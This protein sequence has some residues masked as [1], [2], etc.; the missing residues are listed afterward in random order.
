MDHKMVFKIFL[1]L[2][3]ALIT[4]DSSWSGQKIKI[5]HALAMAG[6][7]KYAEDFKH[8]DYANPNAPKGGNIK[9]GA[10]GT[11]DSLNPFII[12]GVPATGIGLI[13]DTLTVQ[14]LDEPF[15]QYGLIAAKI[16]LP[17][18]RSWVIYHINSKAIF[19]DG[20][21]ITAA[22]VVFS[23]NLLMEKGDP[24]YS[25]YWADVKKVEALDDLRVKFYLGDKTNPE[26]A[27]IIGQIQVMPKHYWE[28]RDFTQP[29]LEV[30]IASGPYKVLEFKPGR[31]ITY[32]R[33][34]DYWAKD[35][36]V[37]KG[38][39]NFDT[40]TYDYYR[41]PT[42]SLHAFKAGEYDFRQENSSRA[43]ATA[44]TGPPF[45]AGFIIKEEI[46]N[47]VNQ[48][49]QGFVFNTRRDLF[50]DRKVREAL[51]YAFDFEWTNK[52]LFFGQY[53]RSKSYFS[54]SELAA[55]GLPGPGELKILESYRDQLPG[56]VFDKAYQP[57][58]TDGSGNIRSNIRKALR[59]LKQAGWKI[60][61]KKLVNKK[62]GDPFI[63]ELLL[64]DPAFERVALPFKKNLSRLG[65]EMNIRVVDTAQFINRRRDFD[66]DMIVARIPQSESPG[67]EQREYWGSSAADITGTSNY[68]GI[69]NPVIDDI[70]EQVTSAPGRDELVYTTRALDRVLLWG[71]YVI[72]QW[73]IAKYRVAYWNKFSRPKITARYSLGFDTWWIDAG[74][75][76][77]LLDFKGNLKN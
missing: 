40:M 73:H 61:G 14:S 19:H 36:P 62:S 18:D 27:L 15:T 51:T 32:Q 39:Y 1:V 46:D 34:D 48:G 17:Q 2:M 56:E 26:L 60:Q 10:V 44:Y 47:D 41:D 55:S 8:F 4:A 72:P 76:A 24:M 53:T 45:D 16:E 67:N 77:K 37:N 3:L 11:F 68:A 74:K 54:N 57:P 12:R 59:L 63:L 31:S 52:T 49:M 35:H 38:R 9:L 64:I 43:W 33:H 29:G 5:T 71:Y 70:I 21:S 25:K 65:I 22:D 75:N 6:S 50:K 69:K 30:P 28:S 23:F 42:V 20:A 66:F 58:E 7:P 13:Y